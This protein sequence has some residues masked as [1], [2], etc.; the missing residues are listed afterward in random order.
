MIHKISVLLLTVIC[1]SG[2]NIWGQSLIEQVEYILYDSL[3][4]R[5]MVSCYTGK[6]IAVDVETKEQSIFANNLGVCNRTWITNDTLWAALKDRIT[7]FNLATGEE[8][9]TIDITGADIGI[10][11]VITDGNGYLYILHFG[12]TQRRIYRMDLSTFQYTT[13]ATFPTHYPMAMY[14]DRDYDRLLISTFFSADILSLSLDNG[15]ISVHTTLNMSGHDGIARDPF[16]NFYLSTA[17]TQ[18][19]E[20]FEVY[21]YNEDF[22]GNPELITEGILGQVAFCLNPHNK[23]IVACSF[24]DTDLTHISMRSQ[25]EINNYNFE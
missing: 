9:V 6:I 24:F 16:G 18:S 22:I 11:E 19:N 15:A 20:Y 3:Y 4:N 2:S 23:E 5:Y 12:S 17:S 21:R 14:L 7:A 8:F 13:F 25:I 10:R 1:I